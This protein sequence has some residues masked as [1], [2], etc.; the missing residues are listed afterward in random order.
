V[1]RINGFGTV[2]LGVEARQPD[3]T[4]WATLWITLFFLPVVPLRR[5]RL[6]LFEHRGTGYACRVLERGPHA[7]GGI[8]RSLVFSWLL[9]P[10]FVLA[11]ASLLV[12]EVWRDQLG[13]SATGQNIAIGV[14][15]AWLI[16]WVWGLA[17]WHER[18]LR[19]SRRPSP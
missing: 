5:E 14:W 8:A 15:I 16:G 11:P 2:H 1:A 6:E 13:W 17:E 19:P 12:S 10:A 4:R 7:W 18:R 3:D 9:V